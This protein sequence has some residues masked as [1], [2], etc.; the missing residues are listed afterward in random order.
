MSKISINIRDEQKYA[1]AEATP[2]VHVG[3]PKVAE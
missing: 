3:P 1:A 2:V